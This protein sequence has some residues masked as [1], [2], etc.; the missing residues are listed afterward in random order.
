MFTDYI[1]I[2]GNISLPSTYNRNYLIVS[3]AAYTLTLPASPAN[4][5]NY[6]FID[7]SNGLTQ[8]NTTISPQGGNTIAGAAG[9]ITLDQNGA[10]ATLVYYNGDWKVVGY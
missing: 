3:T 6:T 10:T 2:T 9:S 5:R 4:G 8:Y 7:A 1:V